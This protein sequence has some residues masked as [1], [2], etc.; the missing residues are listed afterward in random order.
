M[1]KS[2]VAALM[3]LSTTAFAFPER[4]VR[5]VVPFP[6]GGATDA[7]GRLIGHELEKTW[8]KKV[9]IVNQ[10]GASG[11]LGMET[12]V[13]SAA[14]GYTLLLASGDV[15]TSNPHIYK[16]SYD[17]KI[18]LVPIINLVSSPQVIVVNPHNKATTIE[19]LI[20]T[21]R[22]SR[23]LFG[24]AGVGTQVHL[25]GEK[26]QF[27]AKFNALHVPYK[28]EGPSLAELMGGHID[29]ASPNI[30]SA[31]G[32]VKEGKLRALVVSSEKR[33]RLLP[34]VPTALER[35]IDYVN[36]GWF[37]IVAPKGTPTKVVTKIHDD[38]KK[39]LATPEVQKKFADRGLTV[40]S[41]SSSN[42]KKQIEVESANWKKIIE[43]RGISVN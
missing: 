42:F 26:L 12:V 28:G 17:P 37:G 15:L 9:F 24:S 21:S 16:L 32:L 34:D 10:A 5:L 38:A 29:W 1:K 4:D 7:V 8:N 3:L 14:D 39:I 6:P 27:V 22:A 18:D 43:Q 40:I 11:T 36:Y 35:K 33:D 23:T 13:R 20:K 30:V 2:V 31:E 19:E 25:S 41:I